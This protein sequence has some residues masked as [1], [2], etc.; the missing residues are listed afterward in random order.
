M[1]LKEKFYPTISLLKIKSC[2]DNIDK[3]KDGYF[4][5]LDL[6]YF[7][8]DNMNYGS[9][10]LS[11]KLIATKIVSTLN[12]NPEDFFNENFQKNQNMIILQIIK[13]KYLLFNLQ[14]Y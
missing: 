12:K 1:K 2:I 4:S 3:D 14:N 7:L 9:T 13:L 8:N 6:I 5:Y 11:W 10:K